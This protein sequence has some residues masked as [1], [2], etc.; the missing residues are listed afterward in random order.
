VVP[1]GPGVITQAAESLPATGSHYRE[2]GNHCTA[3]G[4]IIGNAECL[5]RLCR[6]YLG[7]GVANSVSFAVTPV[8]W[9]LGSMGSASAA[10]STDKTVCI[11]V[12]TG[13]SRLVPGSC[14]KDA[15]RKS[16][17]IHA[18]ILTACRLLVRM[19]LYW[20]APVRVDSQSG[21]FRTAR[22]SSERQQIVGNCLL[23]FRNDVCAGAAPNIHQEGEDAFEFDGAGSADKVV[24]PTDQEK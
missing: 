5:N 7:C 10:R 3:P 21:G 2:P 19:P 1:A 22:H 16:R 8:S 15:E 24:G 6:R 4:I 23:T 18:G 13:K 17:F 9:R 20:Q 11:A 14:G 12:K